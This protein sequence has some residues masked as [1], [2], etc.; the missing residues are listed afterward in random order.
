MFSQSSLPSL[1]SQTQR[2]PPNSPTKMIVKRA[3]VAQKEPKSIVKKTQNFQ[4]IPRTLNSTGFPRMLRMTHKYVECGIQ[5]NYTAASSM[6][7]YRFSVN[8]LF[9]PNHTGTGHQP[10][11]FDT[12]SGLYDH[13]C[14]IASRISLKVN[15]GSFSSASL[16]APSVG[17]LY[18][19]DNSSTSLTRVQIAAEQASALRVREFGGSNDHDNIVFRKNWSAVKAFGPNPLANDKLIGLAGASPTEQQY[20]VFCFETNDLSGATI[21]LNATIEYIAVWSELKDIT[22]S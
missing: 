10:S 8:S 1:E 12:M 5:L 11:Y 14:V 7:V 20:F 22:A 9:D 21:Y 2:T 13:Y 18:V 16:I 15:P 17:T 6:A 3:R 19:D 4:A